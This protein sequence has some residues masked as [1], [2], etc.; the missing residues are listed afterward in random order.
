M[1]TKLLALATATT[2]AFAAP[3]L[4]Q[5]SANQ[6]YDMLTGALYNSFNELGID[7]SSLNELSLS[8]VAQI[9][10]VLDGDESGGVKKDRIEA[11]MNNN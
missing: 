10:N 9:K 2:L 5:S 1:N 3:A 8:Q 7:T 11:I 4:A 6:G